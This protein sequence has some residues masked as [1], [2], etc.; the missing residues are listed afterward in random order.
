MAEQRRY[1]KPRALQ[2]LR[3]TLAC[4]P[5]Q[6]TRSHLEHNLYHN[7]GRLKPSARQCTTVDDVNESQKR[8]RYAGQQSGGECSGECSGR[9]S[10]CACRC[11][12]SSNR[13]AFCRHALKIWLHHSDHNTSRTVAVAAV[14]AVVMHCGCA[15]CKR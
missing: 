2:K 1:R 4:V 6:G 8:I 15:S 10:M 13:K 3:M 12:R 7:H 11:S 5:L 9:N 14:V